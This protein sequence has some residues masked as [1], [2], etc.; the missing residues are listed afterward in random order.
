MSPRVSGVSGVWIETMSDSREQ[1]VERA[2]GA[3][4]RLRLC[5]LGVEDPHVEAART[6]RNRLPDPAETDDAERRPRQ[7]LGDEPVR[8]RSVPLTRPHCAVALDDTAPRGEDQREREVCGRGG[9]NA[10]RVR[11]RDAAP[12]GSSTSSRS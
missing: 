5:P 4:L 6:L 9:E 10:R 1:L 11:D 2:I 12:A 3:E 8:P 7:L